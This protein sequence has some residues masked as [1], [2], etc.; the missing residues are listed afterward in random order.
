MDK[1]SAVLIAT[2][3]ALIA[4]SVA[5]TFYRTMVAK[6]YPVIETPQ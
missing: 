3:F 1:K 4:I 5:C 6:D 2:V